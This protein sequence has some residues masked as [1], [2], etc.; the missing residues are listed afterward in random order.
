[1]KKRILLQIIKS[2]LLLSVFTSCTKTYT[3]DD[4]I[5]AIYSNDLET[6]QKCLEQGIDV[7]LK[8][9]DGSTMFEK[10]LYRSDNSTE[11][12][13]YL[14]DHGAA[15]QDLRTITPEK[16]D[17][18][19]YTT[20]IA[21]DYS[22]RSPEKT[23]LLLDHGAD[24]NNFGDSEVSTLMKYV[25]FLN[26]EKEHGTKIE[27]KN[28]L[29]SMELILKAGA[30]PNFRGE[31]SG[32]SALSVALTYD[33]REAVDLLLKYGAKPSVKPIKLDYDF[34]PLNYKE[35]DEN[36]GVTWQS[37]TYLYA[38]NGYTDLLMPYIKSGEINPYTKTPNGWDYFFYAVS[39]G[40]V[41]MVEALLP[42][43]KNI[44]NMF[45]DYLSKTEDGTPIW[46]HLSLLMVSVMND[47]DY[48]ESTHY[49]TSKLLLE[50]GINRDLVGY[51]SGYEESTALKEA[52]NKKEIDL[53]LSYSKR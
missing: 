3:E 46:S 33:L 14:L 51:Y 17:F 42:Y 1:M 4:Y 27:Y 49:E 35:Y 26:F 43:I 25:G 36:Y 19:T 24:P 41:E 6:V 44:N 47:S 9:S 2:L 23:Q 18:L 20:E 30:D 37:D 21:L 32:L 16:Q 5:T 8:D 7:N 31:K 40:H 38:A 29:A 48:I 10:T 22:I 11:F 50:S 15:P 12:V 45:Y 34:D 52:K 28:A 13:A 53:L 39:G